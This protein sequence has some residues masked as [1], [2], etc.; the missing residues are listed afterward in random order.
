[1]L[2]IYWP[3]LQ[4]AF[5][6][7]DG[8]SILLAPGVRLEALSW[9]SIG[10]AWFSGA[11]GPSG[12]PIAQ[13]SFALNY[14]FSGFSPFAFKA[15][16]LAIHG[17]CGLLVFGLTQRLLKAT[18]PPASSKN[19]LIASGLVSAVWLLH[20]IQLLPVLH[21]VQRM[22]SLSALFLLAAMLLH[23]HGR[24]RGARAGVAWLTL[25]WGLLWPFSFFS[26]E[27]GALFPIFALAW[28][29][30]VRRSMAGRLDRFARVFAALSA[31]VLLAGLA[32]ALS[33][34]AHWLWSGYELRGFSLIERVLTEG[35]VLWIY[36]GLIF[37]PRLQAFGLYHDD[38]ALSTDLLAPWT[39]LPAL[40]GLAGLVWLT[41][42]FR[43]RAPLLALGIAW[44]L[45]G[46]AL[47][48]TVLPLE[49][50]HEH[51]N[52]LPLFGATLVAGWALLQVL[53]WRKGYQSLALGVAS[54][55]LAAVTVLTALRAYPY[56][57]EV[58]RTLIEAGHHPLSPRAQ[59][60]AAVALD[61]LP[62]AAIPH[63]E[64]YE[65]A[66]QHYE[67]ALA[68]DPGFK[69]GG[70]GLIHLNCK[71]GLP[72]EPV[73]I[74]ELMHRLR[75][76]PFAPGDQTVLYNV[77]EMA[78]SGTPCLSRPEVDGLFDAAQANPSVTPEVQAILHSW[79]ADYLWLHAR[80]MVAARSAL[81]QSLKLNPGNLSNRLKWA[82]LLLISGEL[83]HARQLLLDL[84]AE[85]FSAE[86]RKTINELLGAFKIK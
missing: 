73:E 84:R 3:G 2:A 39:T 14:Y 72:P 24:E 85:N 74:K 30:T 48:S 34:R 42:R 56:G 13:L 77:K 86:E 51:R 25:A 11:A 80:D 27:T 70:L 33:P 60:E 32:Y 5:F 81:G 69:M 67:Q 54:T 21:V 20:P 10:Q 66:R 53:Q 12:R 57:D 38:I 26:K 46:H 76:T 58:H 71:A 63:S 36:L 75:E 18:Q 22:T 23:I 31:L 4:G 37:A 45:I 7:D 64:I 41:W 79:H 44:F 62:Q 78:I 8:P 29:L 83:T 1:M 55:A 49:I 65:L 35:R 6:F 68:L 28:E 59:S 19:V 50:A 9:E 15:T 82:Q 40:L 16:N 47:E 61:N 52:Y 43:V 17:V